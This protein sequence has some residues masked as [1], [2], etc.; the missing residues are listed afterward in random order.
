MI[1]LSIMFIVGVYDDFYEADFKLKFLLQIIVSKIIIDQ[2]YV[3]DSFQGIFGIYE[4][5]WA[6]AQLFTSFVFLVIVNSLNFIDGIDGLAISE[7][8]KE[9]TKF[10]Y[11]LL[12]FELITL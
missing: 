5:P 7:V 11:E 9:F 6:I 10:E 8:I 1:P 2:G 4:L 12:S 3:I